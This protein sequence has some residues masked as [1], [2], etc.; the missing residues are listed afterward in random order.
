MSYEQQYKDLVAEIAAT[1]ATWFK[2]LKPEEKAKLVAARLLAEPYMDAFCFLTQQSDAKNAHVLSL[3][4]AAIRSQLSPAY[5]AL[6]GAI[7]EQ[8]RE[9]F[10]PLIDEDL[11]EAAVADEYARGV[12]EEC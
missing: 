10:I 4:A 11:R 9:Y 12:C 1:G 5:M 2:N 8:A 7:V 6:A 3:A